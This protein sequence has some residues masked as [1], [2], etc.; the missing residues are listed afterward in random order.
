MRFLALVLV[1]CGIS[2]GG[3]VCRWDYSTMTEFCTYDSIPQYGIWKPR[4]E[5][6]QK[7][8]PMT[9]EEQQVIQMTNNERQVRAQEST[10]ES[11]KTMANIMT[12]VVLVTIGLVVYSVV[13]F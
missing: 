2:F 6:F 13:A 12:G 4:L 8:T 9:V 3:E 1:L 11:V 7:T 10:A 5:P